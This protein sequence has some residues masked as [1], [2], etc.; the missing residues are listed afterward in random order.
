MLRPFAA[1][2]G[3][4][5]TYGGYTAAPGLRLAPVHRNISCFAAL[6]QFDFEILQS[7]SQSARSGA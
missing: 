1:K 5:L 3:L 2:R 7:Q 6:E 4:Q